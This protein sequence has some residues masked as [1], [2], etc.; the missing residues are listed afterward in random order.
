MSYKLNRH[1]TYDTQIPLWVLIQNELKY[2]S[3]KTCML[4]FI[5]AL[6]IIT[7]TCK[8]PKWPSTGEWIN[9]VW[10]I[11]TMEYYLAVKRMNYQYAKQHG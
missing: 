6:S 3:A 1:S 8:Q 10:Y 4:M 11:R 2:A 9:Y 7:K 5:V